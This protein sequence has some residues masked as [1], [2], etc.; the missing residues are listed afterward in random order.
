[1]NL[2]QIVSKAQ[3]ILGDDKSSLCCM[4]NGSLFVSCDENLARSIFH[5]LTREMGVERVR[6]EYI[7]VDD[8]YIYDFV[9]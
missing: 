8:T 2:Q 6:I 9:A 5:S 1:M 7:K 3:E 4:Y